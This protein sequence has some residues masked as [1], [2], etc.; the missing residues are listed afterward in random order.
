MSD[1]L[2]AVEGDKRFKKNRR[3]GCSAEYS[4]VL[5]SKIR[6]HDK[7]F[8]VVALKNG[9][10]PGRLGVTVSKRTARQAVNRN[11]IKRV[12]RE[13][14]RKKQKDLLGLD[15]VAVARAAASG[16]ENLALFDSLA[17]HW[18]SVIQKARCAD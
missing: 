7:L 18:Q 4:L 12:V 9:G 8:S 16:S 5:S 6:S 13:S 2:V 11:R 1:L 3:L 14:F 10:A 15:L 17:C